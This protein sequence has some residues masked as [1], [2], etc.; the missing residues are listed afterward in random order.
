MLEASVIKA[1]TPRHGF[2]HGH[3]D[4]LIRSLRAALVAARSVC[5]QLNPEG[6]QQ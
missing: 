3:Y 2:D 5:A 1:G 4:P 6:G